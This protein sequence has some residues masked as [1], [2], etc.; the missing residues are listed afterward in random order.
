MFNANKKLTTLEMLT[1]TPNA[2]KK[3]L[4]TCAKNHLHYTHGVFVCD[5][6]MHA[7]TLIHI[8]NPLPLYDSHKNQDPPLFGERE[9]N[10]FST[11]PA[12]TLLTSLYYS[13]LSA[14]A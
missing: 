11:K 3:K 8:Y 10:R 7:G 4:K 13:H 6:P 14:L 12:Y 9:I 2:N 5:F 1:K